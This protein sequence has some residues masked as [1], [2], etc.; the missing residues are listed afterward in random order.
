M[1]LDNFLISQLDSLKEQVKSKGGNDMKMNLIGAIEILKLH[2]HTTDK[3]KH[4]IGDA[5]VSEAIDTV[6]AELE[7]PRY[8]AKDVQSFFSWAINNG[9]SYGE[10]TELWYNDDEELEAL[11]IEEVLN[12]WEEQK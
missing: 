11:K 8:S 7:K 3:F 12:L 6:V 5:Y 10:L 9:W 4:S 1:N 2:K